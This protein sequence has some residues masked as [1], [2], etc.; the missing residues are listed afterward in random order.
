MSGERKQVSSVRFF[1]DGKP[2]PKGRPR[3]T[4]HGTY[5][6]KSTRAYETAVR[7]AWEREGVMPFAEGE[8]LELD[9]VAYFPIPKG[10]PKKR[11]AEMVAK[12]Y[13]KR[14][15]LDNIVKA[16]MDALNGYAYPDDAAIWNIAARKRYTNEPPVTIVTLTKSRS[17]REFTDEL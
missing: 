15:D 6:P 11:R 10:T 4:Q 17:A 7:T 16:V 5:T 12:P 13:T 14:G 9:V 3:V 8:A 1:V 2:V